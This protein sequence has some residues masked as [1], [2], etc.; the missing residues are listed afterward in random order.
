MKKKVIALTIF[1]LFMAFVPFLAAKCSSANTL[2]PTIQHSKSTSDTAYNTNLENKILCGLVAANYKDGFSEETLKAIAII[3]NTNYKY[4]KKSFDTT[5][6]SVC[7]FEK[8]ADS[9]LKD[10]YPQIKSAVESSKNT[11][12]TYNDKPCYIPFSDISNG[13]T[14][15]S[16]E[17]KYITAVASPWDCFANNYDKN[18]KCVGISLN[19]IDYLCKNG[20]S[21]EKAIK[22]YLP[23]CKIENN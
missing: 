20:D 2:K 13:N 11:I 22:W 15:D 8:D 16:D 7:I 19:G 9:K 1:L 18:C 6:K 21:A 5:D 10:I 4:D 23:K 17:Y 12:I 14:V 3:L